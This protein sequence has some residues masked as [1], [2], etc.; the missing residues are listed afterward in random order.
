MKCRY[1]AVTRAL[2]IGVTLQIAS[3]LLSSTAQV[4][5]V[6]G[7]VQAFGPVVAGLY[8]AQDRVVRNP[9]DGDPAAIRAGATLFR[10]RCAECH[11]AD[12]KG[13]LGPDLTTLWVSGSSDDRT[14]RTVRFGVPNSYMPP[15]AAPDD[16]LWAIVAYLKSIS[17]ARPV[18]DAKGN[19]DHGQQIFGS[20]CAR[21]HRVNG[22]GGH[23]GPD[24][25]RIGEIQSRAA[26]VRAIREP[27]VSIA[28]GY[29]AVTLITRDGQRISGALKSQD[30]F[31]VQ[32]M[33][34]RERL[35]GYLKTDLRDVIYEESSLMPDYGLDRL[36]GPDLDDLLQ[37]LGTLRR[38]ESKGR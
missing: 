30:A 19:A 9:R 3:G 1:V 34:A 20:T 32:V 27:S 22:R 4:F 38:D 31:S 28:A 36:S 8:A 11:G 33:D 5:G 21:C 25:S 2:V 6:H 10:E 18:E 23:L 37:F 35:Q 16:E 14:F 24:L 13:S 26:L 12:A 15:S 7:F 17:S 29:R